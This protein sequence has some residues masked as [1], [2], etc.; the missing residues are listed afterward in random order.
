MVCEFRAMALEDRLLRLLRGYEDEGIPVILLKGAA[1][2]VSSYPRFADRPMGDL[3]VLISPRHARRAWEVAIAQGWVWDEHVYPQSHYQA[4]HHLPPLFDGART[5]ARLELHT[6]LSLSSHPFSLT[7]EDAQAVSRSAG[8]RGAGRA[9]ILDPE[10][11]LIHICVH[12]A[13]GHLA[14][15]GIWRLARDVSAL[16]GVPLDW[17]RVLALS[18]TYRAQLSLYWSLRLID[19][20]CGVEVAP[21]SVMARVA[22]AR[23]AWVCRVLE[24]HLAVHV[25]NR[26]TPCPSEKLRRFM[27][28][29]AL[30]PNRTATSRQRPWD[31]EPAR[32]PAVYTGELGLMD[33]I[34]SQLGHGR[35]W[36]RYFSSLS[37]TS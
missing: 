25:I 18:E 19:G 4:H 12:F 14:S 7:F 32:R 21:A 35:E 22:P 2:A 10:H 16:G 37:A 11:S 3:D 36:R 13:W 31:S 34:R 9:R 23:P 20:L 5:G 26:I 6:A 1:L 8:A 24:R 30:E 17:D 15:L 29:L 27:W 28:S 33:R